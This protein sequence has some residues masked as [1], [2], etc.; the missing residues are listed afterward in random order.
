MSTSGVYLSLEGATIVN[1]GY[2]NVLDIPGTNGLRCYTDKINCCHRNQTGGD[3]LGHWYFPN[4]TI[5]GSYT[6][7]KRN[8]RR[9]KAFTRSRGQSFVNL[10]IVLRRTTTL[11][12]ERGRF[13][14]IVPNA[15]GVSTTTFANICKPCICVLYSYICHSISHSVDIGAVTISPIGPN[16]ANEGEA[17]TL[18]CSA[19][20]A[21]KHDSPSPTFE[22]FFGT[23]NSSLPSL[24]LIHI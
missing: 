8:N 20:V 17:F 4:G 1:D 11:P 15:A 16:I 21:T 12:L 18:E 19:Y 2:V 9:N 6:D 10:Y 23:T 14:C 24:S 5:I 13:Y 3:A 22:W 7:N